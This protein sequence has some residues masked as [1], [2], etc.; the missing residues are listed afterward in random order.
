MDLPDVEAQSRV[1]KILLAA[2][3]LVLPP[4]S[5]DL[6]LPVPLGWREF[7]GLEHVLHIVCY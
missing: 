7:S 4:F 1:R 2:A 3:A 6:W 5:V